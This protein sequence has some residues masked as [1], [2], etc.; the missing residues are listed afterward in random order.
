MR[1]AAR[2][3][4]VNESLRRTDAREF[5]GIYAEQ[6]DFVW[7]S[8]RRLGV[9]PAAVED[10][11]QDTF[12]IF[13]RRFSDLRPDASVK[14]FLFGIALRVAHDYRRSARRKKTVSLDTE[15]QLSLDS[16][17]FECTAKARAARLLE[18]FLSS[19]DDDKRAVF[20]LAELE[21]MS[22]PEIS[23]ALSLKQNTVYSRLRVARE[24]FLAFLALEGDG[25]E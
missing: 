18:R 10:A 23:E 13:H 20:V 6:F 7:R 3:L 11:A 12:M 1:T 17:P 19:L 24:R 4:A 9:D 16:G 2:S 8:L 21:E 14:A 5:E 15:N 25:H 22:G